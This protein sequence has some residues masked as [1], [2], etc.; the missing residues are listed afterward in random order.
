MIARQRAREPSSS[1]PR[2]QFGVDGPVQL[3]PEGGGC[4]LEGFPRLLTAG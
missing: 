4:R 3:R 2:D 1:F